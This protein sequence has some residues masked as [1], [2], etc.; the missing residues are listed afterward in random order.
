MAFI[1]P[2][3]A[4][5]SR[6]SLWPTKHSSISLDPVDVAF[7][8]N[9]FI[10]NSLKQT[11]AKMPLSYHALSALDSTAFLCQAKD[12]SM[13][14]HSGLPYVW[15]GPKLLLLS[16]G[17]EQETGLQVEQLGSNW[18]SSLTCYATTL[19]S[20]LWFLTYPNCWYNQN[21]GKAVI[22]FLI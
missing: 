7:K 5:T 1:R 14:L 3:S 12:K 13:E 19:A 16:Q 21:T 4:K 17:H 2:P 9:F 8:F 22:S 11:P 18:S 10:H 6:D 20:Q 15:Q